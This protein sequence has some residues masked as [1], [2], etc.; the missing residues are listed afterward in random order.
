[1]QIS[2][3]VAAF[4]GDRSASPPR[5]TISLSSKKQREIVLVKE[6]KR[7]S[8]IRVS[9]CFARVFACAHLCVRCRH[10]ET[11]L[12]AAFRVRACFACVFVCVH[13]ARALVVPSFLSPTSVFCL[14][15]LRTASVTPSAK[16]C[17]R[18]ATPCSTG[19]RWPG[20]S[21][22]TYFACTAASRDR[23]RTRLPTS[24]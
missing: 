12:I 19:Y 16:K 22:T 1:M 3:S 20:S 7:Q 9:A 6:H 10:L 4:R 5:G 14:C 11:I 8:T 13:P 24:R 21:T 2:V 17:G 18:L 23:C 15:L